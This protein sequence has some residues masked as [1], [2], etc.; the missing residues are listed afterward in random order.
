MKN[1]IRQELE[2]FAKLCSGTQRKF[3]EQQLKDL[4]DV[5][6]VPLREVF[7]AEEIKR[8]KKYVQPKPKMCYRNAHRL[9]EVFPEKGIE[10]VEG[11]TTIFD[12]T[13]PIEHAWNKVGDKYVDITFELALKNDVT[14][15]I[16]MSLGVYSWRT[17]LQT[18][19]ATGCYGDIYRTTYIN[20]NLK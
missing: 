16:Y 12:G 18:S 3:Y 6:V 11:Y 2:S 20:K 8:I 17:L 13:F 15:E 1:S 7:S 19:L 10:Y 9:C 14:K 4:K 5:R